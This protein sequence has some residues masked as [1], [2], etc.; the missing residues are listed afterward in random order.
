MHI[1][2]QFVLVRAAGFA[3]CGLLSLSATAQTYAG[4]QKPKDLPSDSASM[5][6]AEQMADLLSVAKDSGEVLLLWAQIKSGKRE[7]VPDLIA[8][9]RDGNPRA[10]NVVGYMFDNGEGVQADP[11]KAVSYFKAAAEKFPL[12]KYNLGV[13]TLYGRGTKQDEVQAMQL[14]RDSAISAGI[15]QACVQ[16]ALY[17]LKKNE[18]DDALK[19]ANEGSNRGSVKSF[20]LLGRVL[21]QQQKF[22]EAATW[23]Q[24]A[25]A[26]SE[27]NAPAV[28]SM[29]Y[30]DGKGL[31]KSPTMG[32]AWWLIYTSYSR[33][34]IGNQLAGVQ[35]F[36]LTEEEQRRAIA[37]ANNW[38]STHGVE[39]KVDY[40]K[41][42]LQAK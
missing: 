42:L 30:R 37:F 40:R 41:T 29:M 32:A 12:A 19:W 5:G 18:L 1:S 39:R 27:P 16:L 4:G 34:Q 3:I 36:H 17:H 26:A 13:M 28:I 33:K 22:A 38:L 2:I 20:Y 8:L 7:A 24:K 14:F 10:Q 21:Y 35:S 31:G 9:A 25:A 15:E 11:K 6:I 23:L